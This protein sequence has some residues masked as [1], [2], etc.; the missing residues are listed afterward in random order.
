MGGRSKLQDKMLDLK[1]SKSNKKHLPSK[2]KLTRIGTND[3]I[4][5]NQPSA[6]Y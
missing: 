3:E 2:D 4:V 6:S 1:L 5:S